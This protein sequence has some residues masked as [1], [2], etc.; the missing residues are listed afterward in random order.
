MHGRQAAPRRVSPAVA[1]QPRA[2]RLIYK[3]YCDCLFD[4]GVGNATFPE[5]AT[6]DPREH[7]LGVFDLWGYCNFFGPVLC[8]QGKVQV[9]GTGGICEDAMIAVSKFK[10]LID[11]EFLGDYNRFVST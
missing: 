8:V 11:Y 7:E 9:C 6:S 2:C 3:Y 1:F 5:R 4:A 10:S